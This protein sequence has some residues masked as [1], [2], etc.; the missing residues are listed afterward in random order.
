MIRATFG[1]PLGG[2][3]QLEPRPTVHFDRRSGM[4][5]VFGELTAALLDG[6]A[7]RAAELAAR[8]PAVRPAYFHPRD[9]IDL[10]VH[11]APAAAERRPQV[12]AAA[13]SALKGLEAA[14]QHDEAVAASLFSGGAV[15]EAC[16]VLRALAAAPPPPPGPRG[17]AND[18]AGPAE[19]RAL[20]VRLLR[21]AVCRAPLSAHETRERMARAARLMLAVGDH[22]CVTLEIEGLDEFSV[23]GI[24]TFLPTAKVTRHNAAP[25]RDSKGRAWRFRGRA[26]DGTAANGAG[27]AAEAVLGEADGA[28]AAAA[29]MIC[30]GGRGDADVGTEDDETD[31]VLLL[32]GL[33]SAQLPPHLRAG[34]L[35]QLLQAPAEDLAAGLARWLEAQN[36]SGGGGSSGGSGGDDFADPVRIIVKAVARASPEGAAAAAARPALA[37][38]VPQERLV[39]AAAACARCGRS[40]EDAPGGQL[41]RCSG[42]FQASTA[43]ARFGNH[44]RPSAH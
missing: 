11:L 31:A 44:P 32:A 21:A 40:K 22:G 23:Y 38:W 1:R 8:L 28:V 24:M 4:H 18:P 30:G 12:A 42:C 41:R 16:A 3:S 39:A 17:A 20:L 26:F 25:G 33:L 29:E 10:I 35:R 2:G 34:L 6:D 19:T 13:R 43:V 27:P 5:T 15:R 9:M 37:G 7:P 36:G 14:A